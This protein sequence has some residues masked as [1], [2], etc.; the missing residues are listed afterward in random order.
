MKHMKCMQY[1]LEKDTCYVLIND[2][3]AIAMF[4]FQE[5]KIIKLPIKYQLLLF[6]QVTGLESTKF[7]KTYLKKEFSK[8]L[9]DFRLPDIDYFKWKVPFDNWKRYS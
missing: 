3:E 1:K 4:Y 9:G 8:K 6:N 7:F 2:N 5:D